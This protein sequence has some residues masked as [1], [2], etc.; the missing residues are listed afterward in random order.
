MTHRTAIFAVALILTHGNLAPAA[1]EPVHGTF[2]IPAVVGGAYHQP[3]VALNAADVRRQGVLL[4][5]SNTQREATRAA[6]AQA[7]PFKAPGVVTVAY[8]NP[9]I[10][11]DAAGVI[12]QGGFATAGVVRW[13][14][15]NPVTAEVGVGSVRLGSL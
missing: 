12:R 4:V 3:G 14:P 2:S 9:S 6:V 1:A 15:A 10:A 7:E 8:R 5:P 11:S 13:L